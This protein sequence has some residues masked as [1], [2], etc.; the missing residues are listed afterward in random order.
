M[1]DGY[2]VKDAEGKKLNQFREAKDAADFIEK[3]AVKGEWSTSGPATA[4]QRDC[5]ASCSTFP[6]TV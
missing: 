4:T 3:H 6:L 5:A 2:S 1:G